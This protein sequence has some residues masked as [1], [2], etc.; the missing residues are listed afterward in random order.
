MTI[1]PS[2][3]A[4]DFKS[5]RVYH[6][7][8]TPGYTSWVSFFPGERGQ[9]YL[10]CEEVTRPETPLPQASH[11][12][13]YEMG[14]PVGY[15]KSPL[16]MEMV[17]LESVDDLETW[18]VIS[19]EPC[20]QHHSA[21]QFGTAR[22]RDGR[23]LRFMWSCY[24]IDPNVAPN[25]IFYTS[26]D[27]GRTWQK[28]SPFHDSHFVS[29]AHRLRMLRDGTFVLA[30]PLLPRWGAGTDRPIRATTHINAIS[31]GQMTLWFSYD[32]GRT[33][34]GPLPIY[35][36]QRVAETDFVELPEG[37]LLCINSSFFDQPARQIIYRDGRTWTPG[38]MERALNVRSFSDGPMPGDEDPEIYRRNHF[39]PETVCMTDDGILVGCIRQSLYQWSD[40][41]GLT[42]QPLDGAP[43]LRPEMYQPWI[44]HL[45]DGRIACAGHVGE[46]N[47]FGDMDQSLVIH[48]FTV[49][50][51]RQVQIP[52]L[53]VERDFDDSLGRF[54][55]AYTLSLTAKGRP[56][57]NRP[58]E[59]WIVQPGDPAFG[60]RN[61]L[62]LETRIAMGG[63]TFNLHTN[64]QGKAHVALP[65]LDGITDR[66]HQH[67]FV[68]RFN[69][70]RADPTCTA[71]QTPQFMVYT[72]CND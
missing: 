61:L 21:G 31:D 65:E 71:V 55:N 18:Q 56:L 32:Q 68:A 50:V 2:V 35:A 28:Q 6:S 29:H 69:T 27:D 67:R 7:E 24:A 33:W 37:H 23:F 11:R 59:F 44:H 15:D 63:Q 14:Q 72:R 57:A 52:T 1:E 16:K 17:I 30:L 48:T 9:W 51:K 66:Y 26:D 49:S 4:V 62:P 70:D 36:G 12:Q 34:D 46:D 10:T 20:R 64:A 41:L 3:C 22:T 5:R 60:G 8:Q 42:W 19:R 13:L 54:V 40:D 58:V 53:T 25:E 38:T 45:G 39:V 47:A 43:N